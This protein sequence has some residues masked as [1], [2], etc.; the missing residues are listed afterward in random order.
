MPLILLRAEITGGNLNITGVSTFTNTAQV[1]SESLSPD[2][3][4]LEIVQLRQQP[5]ET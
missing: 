3:K 5:L 1:G 2:G 4:M